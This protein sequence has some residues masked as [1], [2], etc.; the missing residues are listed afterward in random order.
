MAYVYDQT[1]RSKEMTSA[2]GA[3][4]MTEASKVSPAL[5]MAL[6]AQLY[7]RLGVA[8]YM[9][10]PVINTVVTNVPGPPVPIYS[11]GAKLVSMQGL[12]CLLDGMALGHVVQSYVNEA[13]ITFTADRD[14]MPDPEFYSQCLQDSFEEMAKA[15]GVNLAPA[16]PKPAPKKAAAATKT[17]TA[18]KRKPRASTAKKSAP[19]KS[20]AKAS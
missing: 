18:T 14:V 19:A 2:L 1:S 3:R 17:R 7:S 20:K 15:A 6:G 13:T 4:Q 5:F 11:A 16:K 8:N 9:V 10:R 12:L